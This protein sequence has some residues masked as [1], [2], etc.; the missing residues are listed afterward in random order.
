MLSM[1]DVIRETSMN[2]T[3]R[4]YVYFMYFLLGLCILMAIIPIFAQNGTPYVVFPL[5]ASGTV[6][7]EQESA[8]AASDSLILIKHIESIMR[9][10]PMWSY[11]KAMKTIRNEWAITVTQSAQSIVST[12]PMSMLN[13]NDFPVASLPS[14]F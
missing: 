9:K 11:G 13:E 4:K 2:K 7:T 3:K 14:G 8:Q 12:Y 1:I 6:L 5:N 10:D